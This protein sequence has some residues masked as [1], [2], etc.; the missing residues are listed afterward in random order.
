MLFLYQLK[1]F[2]IRNAEK[3]PDFRGGSQERRAARAK[4]QPGFGILAPE[5]RGI[6][7]VGARSRALYVALRMHGTIWHSAVLEVCE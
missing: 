5:L 2:R 3:P 7:Y 6:V 1:V 4:I